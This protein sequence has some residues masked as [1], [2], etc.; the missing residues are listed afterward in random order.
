MI[1]GNMGLTGHD[2]R[3]KMTCFNNILSTHCH[4]KCLHKV[5]VKCDYPVYGDAN[6]RKYSSMCL[7]G[8]GFQKIVTHIIKK[9][10]QLNATIGSL[11]KF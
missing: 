10:N 3:I 6:M 9:N 11:L 1:I 7:Y 8:D 4:F 5:F 2:I